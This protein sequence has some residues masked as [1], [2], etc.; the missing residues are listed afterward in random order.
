M[1]GTWQEG[2]KP[3]MST[4]RNVRSRCCFPLNWIYHKMGTKPWASGIYHCVVNV[5][6]EVRIKEGV[7][8]G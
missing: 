2:D 8:D 6:T 4:E 7:A 5:T 3:M 1:R